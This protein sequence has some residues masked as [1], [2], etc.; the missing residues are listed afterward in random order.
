MST[1]PAQPT[2]PTKP[3]DINV[4]DTIRLD[5]L[6][7]DFTVVSEDRKV[8]A[9]GTVSGAAGRYRLDLEGESSPRYYHA[10]ATIPVVTSPPAGEEAATS[11]E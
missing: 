4:G 1:Q 10:T 7:E 5:R 3:R 9:I 2:K 11:T 8:L 6:S